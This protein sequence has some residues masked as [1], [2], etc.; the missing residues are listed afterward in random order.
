MET[1]VRIKKLYGTMKAADTALETHFGE[2]RRIACAWPPVQLD[3]YHGSFLLRY[4]RS[5]K[6]F[7]SRSIRRSIRAYG[8]LPCL[9]LS[10]FLARDEPCEMFKGAVIGRLGALWKTTAG[11]LPHLQVV[12][13]AVAADSLPRTRLIGTVARI[14]VCFFFAL[15]Y[16]MLPLIS[17]CLA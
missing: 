13:D 3:A 15:H 14:Q 10:Y 16:I 9:S 7:P 11:Q 6:G 4:S 12:A 2:T 1:V 17:N 5:F 8:G